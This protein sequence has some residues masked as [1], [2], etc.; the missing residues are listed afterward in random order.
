MQTEVLRS[1]L[2]ERRERLEGARAAFPGAAD[3][4]RLLHEVDSALERMEQGT[5]GLCAVCHDPIE[6]E[7]LATDPLTCFCIDH[8]SEPER[9]ALE[10]D[11]QTAISIQ[12]A[13]LPSA[14]FQAPGWDICYHYEPA[15]PVSGDYCDLIRAPG[16]A[17]GFF[18]LVGDVAGKGIAASLLMSHLHAMFRT[19][20][21]A[22]VALP[23]ALEQANRVFS[24]STGPSHY[25]T[26]VLGHASSSGDVEISNAGHCPPLLLRRDRVDSVPA[27]GIPLGM[28][29]QTRYSACR[30]TLSPGDDLLL[31]SDG[32]TEAYNGRDEQYGAD[33]LCRTLAACRSKSASAIAGGCLADWRAFLNG[34]AKS[35]DVTVAVLRKES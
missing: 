22:G 8:L 18:F 29:L 12:K 2:V 33:R 28:F 1:Q 15:G 23:D 14:S 10:R 21:S 7:R 20:L 34:A 27:T 16:A 25:A 4:E 35:D 31:Y 19:L 17:D 26:L 11:V 6:P 30:Y 32:V 3:V 9:K 5:Y 24:E 13:L